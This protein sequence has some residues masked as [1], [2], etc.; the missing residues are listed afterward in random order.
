MYY[1]QEWLNIFDKVVS[2]VNIKPVEKKRVYFTRNR[3]SKA[4]SSEIGE[5]IFIDVFTKNGFDIIS[6]ERCTLDEQI[7]IIRNCNLVAAIEGSIPHNMLF[8]KAGQKILILNKTY[9]LNMMQMDINLIKSLDVTY[10]DSYISVFP[11]SLGHGPFMLAYNRYLSQFLEENQWNFPDLE[12]TTSKY[13]SRNLRNFERRYREINGG[14]KPIIYELDTEKSAYFDLEHIKD[15]YERYYFIE[16][17]ISYCER[18]TG[19]FKTY[20]RVIN[21]IIERIKDNN[22]Q[23]QKNR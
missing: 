10:V 8:A 15:Y 23:F 5:E 9:G 1:S 21:K 11:V 22:K 3:F 17:Q 13:Q 14:K 19:K 16:N 7:S 2:N 18:I 20:R 6:P 12:L 4:K